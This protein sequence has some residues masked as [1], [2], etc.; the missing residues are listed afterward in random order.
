M[1]N[2]YN[3]RINLYINGKEVKNDISSIRKE[4]YK[5]TNQ[6]SRMTIGSKEYNAH[7]T[8]IKNLRGIIQKHNSD[9]RQTQQSWFSLRKAAEGFNRYFAM[10]TAALASFA[11][12]ALSIKSAVNAYSEFDDKLADV[13]KTTGLT[14]EEV[15]ELN[16]EL[17]KIDTRTAQ[18]DLLNLARVAGKLGI[19][20]QEDILG[21]VR[22]ANQISVALGEDLGGAEDAVREL[23]KLTDIFKL[24]ET[25]GQEEA[26]L[27]IGSAINELGMAST[28]NEGYLVE[29]S[30]RTAGIAP[31]AGVSVQ[32]ILGLAATLDSLGQKAEMSSTAYSKLMTT[33]T[34]KTSEFAKIAGMEIGEFSRLLRQDA[35]EAMI[36][37][38]E[39][40]NKNAGGFEQLVAAL[41]D[42]GIEG[43]RMTSVFGA[44]A[45]NTETLRKQ[46]LLAN[47]AFSDGTSLTN[48]YNIK[49]KTVQANLEKARKRF[50]EMQRELGERLAPAYASVIK[51][52]SLLIKALG[53]TVEFLF[54]HGKQLVVVVAAIT[55]YTVATRLAVMWQNR[56]N[57]ATLASIVGQKLQA[58]AFHAQFAAIALYNT[59]VALLTGRLKVAAIQFRAFSAAMMASPVGIIVG[60]L[61]IAGVALF[62]YYKKAK[63]A[64][65]GQK[66]LN[67]EMQKTED[68][69]GK[70]QY[71]QF[72][73]D[74]GLYTEQII[75]LADGSKKVVASFNA[76]ID[77]LDKFGKKVKTLRQYELE[78]FKQFFEEEIINMQRNLEN[79]DPNSIQFDIDSAKI[80]EFK[81]SL[82]LVK[83][84]LENISKARNELNN[85][86]GTDAPD[87]E[88]VK[89][90]LEKAFA[91][92]QNLLKQQLLEKKLTK[93][94]Y[95]QEQ[96]ELELAHLTAMRELYRQ[97]NEDFISLEGAIID[98]KLAWQ[99][100]L[101]EM[102]ETSHSITGKLVEKERSMFA[103]IDA[104]MDQHMKNYADNL[105]KETEATINAENKKNKA[106]Q[107]AKEAAILASVQSGMAA[108]EN[109][110]TV[111]EAGKAVLNVIRDEI[112]AYIAK[113]VAAQAVKVLETVPPPL[114]FILATVAGAA[115]G[116]LFNKL[117]PEFAQGK[118]PDA[119]FAG[120]PKTGTYGNKP[121]LGIFNEVPGQ[122]ETVIDGLTSRRIRVNHPEILDAIYAVR[123]G[124]IPKYAGGKYP[125]L[126]TEN[127][128]SGARLF[129]KPSDQLSAIDPEF[130]E[131]LRQ[132]MEIN[133]KLLAWKPKVYSEK[134]KKD[135]D[136]LNEIEQNR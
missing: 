42:L 109:A 103:D 106:R 41:G 104:E 78:N 22:A 77:V 96:Y 5:L 93:A 49:N 47:K 65:S 26:L 88:T 105:D 51:K 131:L 15:K 74:T 33:M 69:L 13:R 63:E 56:S 45:N 92:E 107:D 71:D 17:E 113:A 97:H 102:L 10:A 21:F 37:V 9:L 50:A 123:D 132:N 57:A 46:Q 85:D 101:D 126:S 12:V 100:Q 121:Q 48:E 2:S 98:K 44:L 25:Y 1:A 122:P 81:D 80:N 55:A 7:A 67:N 68:L 87:F 28:A 124:R 129:S 61:A 64:A 73:K 76:N 116:L 54:K 115:A 114:S 4:M 135:I 89:A 38:F 95:N 134:I 40:L 75:T 58:L 79:L 11:G 130:K 6:Q 24:K 31:Q 90:G 32:N 14:K 120:R 52:S 53:I 19:T 133:K 128:T 94:E 36:R 23:G 110:K 62:N 83:N 99:Q 119:E 60:L 82:A 29:F 30:K 72:L 108:I 84:E 20:G 16:T 136:E 8:K 34:K 66:Q 18:L 127:A 86:G 70:K 27:K 3:R 125:V 59:A 43:Q 35:N 112:K 111:E 91:L 117:I 118:Y 39:G